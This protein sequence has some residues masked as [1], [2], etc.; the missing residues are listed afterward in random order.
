MKCVR[1]R[2]RGG[3][4]RGAHRVREGE[5]AAYILYNG[6][7]VC[8]TRQDK[9]RRSNAHHTVVYEQTGRLLGRRCVECGFVYLQPRT[10]TDTIVGR[11]NNSSISSVSQHTSRP[12]YTN[13]HKR[14]VSKHNCCM[15]TRM[16]SS[17]VSLLT[18]PTSAYSMVAPTL[19]CIKLRTRHH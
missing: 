9:T 3:Q 15:C 16:H 5:G 11:I 10:Q 19:L 17:P 8:K 6:F 4:P 7:H 2:D 18:S 14:G 12:T 1:T 13:T